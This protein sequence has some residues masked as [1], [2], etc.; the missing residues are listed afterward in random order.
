ME[1]SVEGQLC[2]EQSSFKLYSF[3]KTL[4]S[5]PEDEAVILSNMQSTIS[6]LS[7]KQIES[8]EPI[9]LQPLRLDWFRFQTYTSVSKLSFSLI[10]HTALAKTLN[11]IVFHSKLVD[12]IEELLYETSD[13]SLFW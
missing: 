7:V 4:N 13:M 11:T 2:F 12:S 9:N 6:S 3:V 10:K 1:W 5:L 8:N